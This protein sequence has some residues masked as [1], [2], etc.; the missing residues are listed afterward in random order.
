MNSFKF[1]RLDYRLI[2]T[3]LLI[4]VGWL[5]YRYN[6]ENYTSFEIWTGLVGFV[7]KTLVLIYLM[8]WALQRFLIGRKDYLLFF[9]ITFSI[10]GLVGFLDLLRD[11]YT[12]EPPWEWDLTLPQMLVQCFYNSTPDVAMPVGLLLGKKY[13]ENK[14]DYTQLQNSQKE[15][16]LKALRAQYDPHFLY[17]SLNTIDALIDYSPKEKV[18]QYVSH[19]A[20]LYRY[21]IHQKEE[22]VASLKEELGLAKDYFYLIETRFGADYSFRIQSHETEEEKYLPH[23]ALLTVLENVVKHNK[24]VG[25]VTVRTKIQINNQMVRVTNTKTGDHYSKESL[26][27]GLQNLDKRY[28]LLSDQKLHIEN[29]PEEFIVEMPLLSLVE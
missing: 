1:N 2:T 17:N 9:L 20:S 14:L 16:E 19:L 25:D 15:M 24:A 27:T 12:S 4:A 21:L 29:R 13:Y 7:A 6:V 10:L 5:A 18:K 3:Y 22:E 8:V 26:G 11:Y 23:G 28:R